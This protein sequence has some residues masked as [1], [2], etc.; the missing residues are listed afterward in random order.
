MAAP[1]I[2]VKD[3]DAVELKIKD[4]VNNKPVRCVLSETCDFVWRRV[5]D[6]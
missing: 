3:F 6:P 1:S 5:D 4:L 2:N